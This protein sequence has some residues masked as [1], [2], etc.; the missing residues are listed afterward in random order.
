MPPVAEAPSG[1]DQIADAAV[2]R[3]RR[4]VNETMFEAKLRRGADGAALG[5]FVCECGR[6]RCRKTVLIPLAS[7]DPRSCAGSVVAH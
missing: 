6:L 5:E 4:Y 3:I 1:V 7:F 2:R